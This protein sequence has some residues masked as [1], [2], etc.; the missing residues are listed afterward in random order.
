LGVIFYELFELAEYR[1]NHGSEFLDKDAKMPK[2][3]I[4]KDDL[5]TAMTWGAVSMV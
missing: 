1:E 2:I 4:E 5:A 3:R